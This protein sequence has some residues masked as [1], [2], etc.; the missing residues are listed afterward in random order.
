[1]A[2]QC[3]RSRDGVLPLLETLV[4]RLRMQA[5]RH[6]PPLP[7]EPRPGSDLVR[8]Y[9]RPRGRL[10]GLRP[11][12]QGGITSLYPRSA[13]LASLR[14]GYG[15]RLT[16]C[17]RKQHDRRVRTPTF[18]SHD[19]TFG[20]R[21]GRRFRSGARPERGAMHR[22]PHQGDR[23]RSD[24]WSSRQGAT[25]RAILELGFPRPGGHYLKGG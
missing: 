24:S 19:H 16:Q 13:W 12:R 18:R 4:A 20:G 5:L 2:I 3:E 21:F 10:S 23:R 11:L 9:A 14:Q 6:S 17:A 7:R 25:S 22:S 1:M 15:R 8:Q